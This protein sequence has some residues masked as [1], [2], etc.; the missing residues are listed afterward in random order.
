MPDRE[1]PEGLERRLIERADQ[2]FRHGTEDRW[3]YTG[4]LLREAAGA[5]AEA[6]RAM[7][8]GRTLFRNP[9][10]ACQC[11]DCRALRAMDAALARLD[12]KT[13]ERGDGRDS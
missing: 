7:E 12:G 8:Q 3:T 10:E 4:N 5:L 6:R 9:G 2:A 1:A 13:E 11:D